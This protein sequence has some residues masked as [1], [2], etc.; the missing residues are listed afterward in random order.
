MNELEKLVNERN[1]L[2]AVLQRVNE[3]IESH[4]IIKEGHL[5]MF[6]FNKATSG[7]KIVIYQKIVSGALYE[8]ILDL[9]IPT[10]VTV[11]RTKQEKTYGFEINSVDELRDLLI[12]SHLI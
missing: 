7:A 11:H 1:G 4:Q 3:T 12:F 10:L 9:T 8:I 5:K 6:G 2:V